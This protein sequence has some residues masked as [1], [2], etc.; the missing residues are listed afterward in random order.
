MTNLAN[1]GRHSSPALAGR[2]ARLTA[3]TAAILTAFACVFG[4]GAAPAALSLAKPAF[5]ATLAEPKR[6]VENS[7]PPA[8]GFSPTIRAGCAA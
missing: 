7:A 1:A 8:M 6:G 4:L 2:P 3:A 5:P